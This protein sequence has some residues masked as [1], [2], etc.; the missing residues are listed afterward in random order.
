[1]PGPQEIASFYATYYTHSADPPPAR[2][3]GFRNSVRAAW[4][5]GAP[6]RP[7]GGLAEKLALAVPF[8][9]EELELD[10]MMLRFLPPGRLLD[11]GCGSG[12]FLQRMQ[13][14]GWRVEGVE[15]DPDA[16]AFAR[17]ALEG[18]VHA[19][20]FVEAALPTD[21]FDAV[22]MNQVIEHVPDPLAYLREAARVCRPGGRVVL[23]TPNARALGH[24]I[25]GAD[26]RGL[27]VPRHLHLFTVSTLAALVGQAGFRIISARTTARG[28]RAFFVASR[29]LARGGCNAH[30]RTVAAPLSD[31]LLALAFQAFEDALRWVASDAGEEIVLVAERPADAI[32]C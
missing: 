20:G 13:A 16:A 10:H 3:K 7:Q 30:D 8:V 5:T 24:R 25:F 32:A 31:R 27:E 14:I 12:G 22:T 28:A 11:V 17:E 1:M 21:A 26:W 6:G 19:S 29:M 15:L 23:A 2:M 9:R 18:P 4:A